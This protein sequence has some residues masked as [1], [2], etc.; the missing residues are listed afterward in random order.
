MPRKLPPHVERNF[1]KGR[2]YLYFRMGRGK[3]VRLPDDPTTDDF[4]KAYAD[5]L[6][7]ALKPRQRF[8]G[9]KPH[10]IAA[11]IASYKSSNAYRK[12]RDTT[13]SS[14]STPLEMLREEHGNRTVA[15]MTKQGIEEKILA[16]YADRPGQQLAVLKILRILINH[17]MSLTPQWLASDPSTGIERPKG[18]EFR[19]WTDAEMEAF[20]RRWPLGTKQRTAYE[21]ML[22]VGAARSDVH[23]ITWP[24]F[25]DGEAN[26]SRSKTGVDVNTG[27]T[28][29]LRNALAAWSRKHIT[30]LYTEF[31]KPFSVKGFGNFMRDAIDKA[32]LP[33]GCKPHGLR[34]TLGRRLAD[35]GVSAHDIMAALGHK[36]LTEAQRYT[37]E[38]DRRRGGKRAVAALDAFEVIEGRKQ[39]G[40]AQ[41]PEVGLGK[42]KKGE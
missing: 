17:A 24:Q 38:A 34:K 33:L 36:T 5:C 22:N 6:S 32:G 9:A 11:L 10:S 8:E 3:R 31:G 30:I 29:R 18:G 16:P 2:A 13:K 42:A 23:A 39:N 1:V 25:D 21:L 41:T 19:A 20:E 4:K 27:Q 40:D 26:Y 28:Q 15:G 37:R 12:L 14:Y 7:G 35:A